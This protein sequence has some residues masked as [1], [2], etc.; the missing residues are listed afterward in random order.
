M[1]QKWTLA[2]EDS[3]RRRVYE[4]QVCIEDLLPEGDLG[5]L[6][7]V[8]EVLDGAGRTDRTS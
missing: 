3:L 1:A 6:D 8:P 2:F 4:G 7:L 5:D